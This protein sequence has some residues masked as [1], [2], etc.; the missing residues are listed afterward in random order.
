MKKQQIK[1]KAGVSLRART[2]LA[3]TNVEFALKGQEK[4]AGGATTG[5]NTRGCSRPEGALE[6][7]DLTPLP[8][9][10]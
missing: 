8:G 5:L 10:D 7:P 3:E 1:R 6:P 9:L 4:L 2:T